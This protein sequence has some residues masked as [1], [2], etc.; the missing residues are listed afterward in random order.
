MIQDIQRAVESILRSFGLPLDIFTEEADVFYKNALKCTLNEFDYEDFLQSIALFGENITVTLRAPEL[1][2]IK[3]VSSEEEKRDFIA[4]LQ[5]RLGNEISLSIRINKTAYLKDVIDPHF[6][7]NNNLLLYLNTNAVVSS[8]NY[9][10]IEDNL[11][12]DNRCTVIICPFWDIEILENKY[13]SFLGNKYKDDIVNLNLESNIIKNQVTERTRLQKLY[14]N[15]RIQ[16]NNILPDHLYFKEQRF[17]DTT[18]ILK[19]ANLF[20][21]KMCLHFIANVSDKDEFL[22]RGYKE[23]AIKN[24]IR[25]S[26]QVSLEMVGD[27]FRIY[28][29]IYSVQTQDKILIARNVITIYLTEEDTIDSVLHNLEK[30]TNAFESNVD[31]Y[32]KDKVKSFF[33]KKK[34]LE[35]YVR[36]TSEAFSKQIASVSDNLY[37]SW[38]A[39]VGAILGGVVTY[40][41]K[42]SP[43][44]LGIFFILFALLSGAILGYQLWIANKEKLLLR[45]S[46]DHFIKL[47]DS[48]NEDEKNKITGKVVDD[49]EN[50]LKVMIKGLKFSMIIILTVSLI[51]GF[52]AFLFLTDPNKV[53]QQ[54]LEQQI[55]QLLNEQKQ[56]HKQ[57]D[58]LE[59]TQVQ[60]QQVK[61]IDDQR[62]QSQILKL[63]EQLEIQRQQLQKIMPIR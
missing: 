23:L 58:Q 18:G 55:D 40:S 5:Q 62:F 21:V 22:F 50:L 30:I 7:E 12:R 2:E 6:I 45:N 13:I 61:N 39:L 14:C 59:K 33:D 17:N 10:K 46:F 27:L 44:I 49:K 31:S 8:I 60:Q 28:D 42:A 56:I 54:Q 36:D 47:V 41:A 32:V 11:I 38:L 25:D 37:K 52:S 51:L 48:I 53:Q 1:R 4:W 16:W 35:K 19:V 20:V 63:Q 34:D 24:D 3:G 29:S 26:N 15:S 9:N 57:L 43:L